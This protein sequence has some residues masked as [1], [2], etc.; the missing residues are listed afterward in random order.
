MSIFCVS[1]ENGL[2]FPLI[3]LMTKDVHFLQGSIQK[4]GFC[5][6][7]SVCLVRHFLVPID[8]KRNII[9]PLLSVF[10]HSKSP[11]TEEARI[12]R[13]TAT[14]YRVLPVRP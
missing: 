4:N 12:E 3:I 2:D 14:T 13:I 9:G 7:A 1:T 11:S 8:C 10:A 6:L 5:Q